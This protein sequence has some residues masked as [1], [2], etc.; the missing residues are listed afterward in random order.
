[1]R[2]VDAS[3]FVHAYLKPKR[4][5]T[6][7]EIQIKEAA[8]RIV[9]RLND[10]EEALS[11]SVHIAEI[12]SIMEDYLPLK[13]AQEIENA[14]CLRDTIEVDAVSRSDCMEALAE[15]EQNQLGFTDALA[16][17]LMKRRGVSEIYSFDR[18][19]DHISEIMRIRK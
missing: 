14:L 16:V 9:S 5:L 7:G 10:G 12:A 13:E 1:L 19:F 8:R 2:F 11:S 15:A 3:V 4:N 18:D 6:A 17:V